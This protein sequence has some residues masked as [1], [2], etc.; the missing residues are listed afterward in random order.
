MP[1]GTMVLVTVLV[2]IADSAACPVGAGG[3]VG[4][5]DCGGEEEGKVVIGLPPA[6][7]CG[8]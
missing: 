2:L 1:G 6:P 8:V 4:Q 7:S 5:G 3:R